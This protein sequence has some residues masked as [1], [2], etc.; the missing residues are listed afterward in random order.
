MLAKWWMWVL[1]AASALPA[2][3]QDV[4]LLGGRTQ[5]QGDGATFGFTFAYSHDIARNLAAG[6]SYVNEGHVPGHHR[7]GVAAQLWLQGEATPGLQLGVAAGPYQYFDTTLAESADGFHDAHGTGVLYSAA[8]TW[9]LRRSPVFLRARL[10]R[11]EAYGTPDSTQFLVGV[12]YRLDQDGSSVENSNGLA[13][14]RQNDQEVVAYAGQTVVN[15]F[16]S[17]SNAAYAVEYRHALGPVA[18]VSAM[19][20]K[21]GDARLIRRDGV[22]AQG[23]LEPSFSDDRWTMGLGLGAYFAVDRYREEP[24]H[25]SP[26]VATT[27]SYNLSRRWTARLNWYRVIS[28]YDRDSDVFLA[29]VG[30]RF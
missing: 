13:W 16:E 15:S 21:E 5:V 8:A 28:N 30:Y 18:R 3:G 17:E 11:V 24:R 23:W 1:G 7:D 22:I 9:R 10:D 29:G 19:W 2:F 26:L 27:L 20:M 14:R 6:F 25:V 4:A 12:G